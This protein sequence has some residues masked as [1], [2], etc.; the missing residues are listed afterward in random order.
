MSQR[1]CEMLMLVCLPITMSFADSRYVSAP[2]PPP[3]P[4]APSCSKHSRDALDFSG[5]SLGGFSLGSNLQLVTLDPYETRK[6]LHPSRP[7]TERKTKAAAKAR[8][9]SNR[10]VAARSHSIGR[11]SWFQ[12]FEGNAGG[13]QTSPLTEFICTLNPNTLN[14]LNP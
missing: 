7:F 4:P 10:Q 12:G 6:A 13:K 2:P 14:P 3:R 8:S 11:A 9:S 1:R 5:W